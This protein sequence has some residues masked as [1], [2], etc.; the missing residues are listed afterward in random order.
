MLWFLPRE[1]ERERDG[2]AVAP[3]SRVHF[4]VLRRE[5]KVK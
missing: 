2:F 4:Y 1:G 5:E 3:C